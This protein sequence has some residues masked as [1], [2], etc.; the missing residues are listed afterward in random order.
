MALID[1]L[2]AQ[3]RRHPNWMA[4]LIFIAIV[5]LCHWPLVLHL[6]THVVG[7]PF[8]DVFGVLWDL[9]W[10][11]RAVFEK[12]VSPFFMP[13]VYYPHGFYV[14]SSSPPMWW[15]VVLSPLT[16][17][18]G[19]VVTYNVSSLAA[20][21][22]AGL[23]M[24][25]LV[26]YLGGQWL[27]GILAG[28]I[29]IV[30][31]VLTIRMGGH[32][33]ILLS[34]L[35]L[36]YLAL[37]SHKAVQEP[38]LRTWLLAGLLLGLTSLGHWQFAFVAPSLP[39]VLIGL[40][41]S[42]YSLR[43]RVALIFKIGITALVAVL[44]FLAITIYARSQMYTD[45]PLFSM[46]TADFFSL[47]IDRLF[48]P[49]PLSS[50]WGE[51]SLAVFPVSSE[52]S[53]ISIGYLAVLGSVIGMLSKWPQ[54]RA[55]LALLAI[56]VIVAMGITLHWNEQRVVLPLPTALARAIRPM[57]ESIVG[58]DLMPSGE[59]T[60]IPLPLAILYRAFPILGVT[61]VWTRYMIVGMLAIGVLAGFGATFIARRFLR[62]A[63]FVVLL[64]LGLVLLEGLV[65]PYRC[66]TDVSANQ[67]PI[68]R[69][70][71]DQQPSVSLIEY[72]LPFADKLSMYRQS[73]HHQRLVNGYASV[74]PSYFAEASPTLG[75]WPNAA[76][77]DLLRGWR[78]DYVLVNGN[79]DD[80]FQKDILPKIHAVEGLCLTRTDTEPERNRQTLLF[81]ILQD[82]QTCP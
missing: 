14:S 36:P 44:P 13:D 2:L 40:G 17:L 25:C 4:L 67:R 20:Y 62:F 11:Q 12:Q 3:C 63:H 77:V 53:A 70:L 51:W 42:S 55:Y 22:L 71:A 57:V 61:R 10:A 78:V 18:W 45:T 26:T 9:D 21:I 34:S 60:V 54:R 47:S 19:P 76:G 46:A 49:N 68:D 52:A 72:P 56:A 37:F 16:R 8:D 43:Q 65:T 30:A 1:R 28:C 58:P 79:L 39:L 31:P 5:G 81:R 33:D 74:V 23:G 7:R 41:Q 35:W 6:S 69:W 73:L 27:G 50:I 15:F 66:F 32:M 29:Y 24:Y 80:T 64:M 82:G 38:G 75:T 48:V 59:A